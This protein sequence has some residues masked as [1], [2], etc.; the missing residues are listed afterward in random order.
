MAIVGGALMPPLQGAI[1]DRGTILGHPAV[2]VSYALPTLCFVIVSIYGLASYRR[3][4][5]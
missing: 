2:N 4:K 3:I 1:I 5:R